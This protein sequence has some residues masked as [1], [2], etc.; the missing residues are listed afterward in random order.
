MEWVR[1]YRRSTKKG[2]PPWRGTAL[3]SAHETGRLE[4][5]VDVEPHVPGRHDCLRVQPGR[6]VRVEGLVVPGDRVRIEQVVDVHAHLR[7]RPVVPED[8]GRPEVDAV[9]LFAEQC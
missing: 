4:I 1:Y 2:L 3:R 7:A 5:D 6:G 9:P 8:L